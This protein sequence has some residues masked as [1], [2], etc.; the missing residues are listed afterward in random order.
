M[1]FD[2]AGLLRCSCK[3]EGLGQMRRGERRIRRTKRD[4]KGEEQQ[5]WLQRA[6]V[7]GPD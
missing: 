7:D 2:G 5:P 6:A 3:K 4:G 1:N